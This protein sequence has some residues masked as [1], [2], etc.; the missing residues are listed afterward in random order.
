MSDPDNEYGDVVTH[1]ITGTPAHTLD[2]RFSKRP[3]IGW[4]GANPLHR[5]DIIEQFAFGISGLGQTV[6]GKNNRVTVFQVHGAYVKWFLH[7]AEHRTGHRQLFD[8][9]TAA[10]ERDIVSAACIIEP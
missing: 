1:A 10:H 2:Q 8:A 9:G 6:G 7:D 4:S 5:S 3:R